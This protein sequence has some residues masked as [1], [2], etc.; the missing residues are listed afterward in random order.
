[1]R[2][3][4]T[5]CD[6]VRLSLR[7]DFFLFWGTSSRAYRE[8]RACNAQTTKFLLL[9][10]LTFMPTWMW[11]HKKSIKPGPC[12]P[13]YRPWTHHTPRSEW[14]TYEHMYTQRPSVLHCVHSLVA[15]TRTLAASAVA[16]KSL[17]SLLLLVACCW[18]SR[19]KHF[20]SN[21]QQTVTDR[22][23]TK[24]QLFSFASVTEAIGSI[25]V[26]CSSQC[27]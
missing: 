3:D 11:H 13:G 16:A 20:S 4:A 17:V 1:M 8:M 12:R 7:I 10:K 5:C 23:G 21:N 18:R 24:M 19:W 22:S 26:F 14:A 2:C 15:K 27:F 9:L 6:I 25:I